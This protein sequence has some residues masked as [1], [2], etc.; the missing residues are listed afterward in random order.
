MTGSS[1]STVN[2]K[3]GPVRIA[4]SAKIGYLEQKGV[5]GSTKKVRDEVML[6]M[7]E[8]LTATNILREIEN[9]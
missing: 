5:S 7:S 4:K 2:L 3:G 9:K 1:G 8:L 6:H